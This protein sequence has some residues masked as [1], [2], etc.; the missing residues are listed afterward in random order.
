MALVSTPAAAGAQAATPVLP[1][2]IG[3]SLTYSARVA[4]FGRV[5][6]ARMWVDGP[7]EVRG[8]QT[9]VLRFEFRARVG[10]VRAE[11]RTESWLDPRSMAA[12][13]FHK[14]ERHPLSRHDERVELYPDERRWQGEDGQGGESPTGAPLDELSFMFFLRT[15]PL[16]ADTVFTFDR[17][18]D[19]ARNPT[20]VR[21][22]GRETVGTAA[23]EF[24][25]VKLEM[26][27]RDARRYKGEGVIRINLTDD[28]RRLPVRIESAMPVI[29]A[30]VLTLDAHVC[31]P[32]QLLA[33]TY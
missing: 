24:R 5:G 26:R 29:G 11:D 16:A 21:V 13:R 15:L 6:T 22:V 12:L 25:T 17:H 4:R 10:P 7:V 8:V 31:A 3:D 23:G 14:H 1:F 18:F 9:W 30:A 28:D 33:R 27:V 2:A 20:V 19:A 32:R